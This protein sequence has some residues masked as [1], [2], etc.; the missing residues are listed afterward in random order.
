MDEYNVIIS[1]E[2]LTIPAE[3]LKKAS[4]LDGYRDRKV[5]KF[6]L[7]HRMCVRDGGLRAKMPESGDDGELKEHVGI[8]VLNEKK[9]RFLFR[10]KYMEYIVLSVKWV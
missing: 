3:L 1:K 7:S 10:K 8:V 4:S 6:V 5:R 2:K 9:S